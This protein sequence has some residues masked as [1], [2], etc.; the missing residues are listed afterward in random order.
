MKCIRHITTGKVERVSD[1]E[2]MDKIDRVLT[3]DRKYQYVPKR[4]WK[5]QEGKLHHS[6]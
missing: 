3:A 2:A 6:I 4:E 5:A 1:S